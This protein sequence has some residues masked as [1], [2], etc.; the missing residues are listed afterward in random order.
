MSTCTKC[1]QRIAE[2]PTR[3]SK[4]QH[5]YDMLRRGAEQQ[6]R[7]V[8]WV[9]PLNTKNALIG[10]QIELYRGT[11][12]SAVI[13]PA[14]VFQDAI[15]RGAT[16]LVVAHNHPSG[17]AQPS[18]EDIQLTGTLR[19]AGQLLD[20]ELLDHIVIGHGSFVSMRERKM[21]WE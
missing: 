14:E 13:R 2:T 18:P 9:L 12:N 6:P 20:I 1:G 10:E 21:G 15:K 5:F 19:K 11:V 17:D 8:F 7:E 3:F 16:G 4:P